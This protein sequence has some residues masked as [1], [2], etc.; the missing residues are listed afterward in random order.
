M[1]PLK[2]WKFGGKSLAALAREHHM[3]VST[4]RDRLLHNGGN[5]EKALSDPIG[6]S[7]AAGRL[8]ARRSPWR[9][10]KNSI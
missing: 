2:G 1:S 5:L 9:F 6:T 8:G 7:A 10:P 3:A 4:L